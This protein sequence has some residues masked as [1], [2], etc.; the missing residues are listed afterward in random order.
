LAA[1]SPSA[2][3]S[4]CTSGSAARRDPWSPR[5]RQHGAARRQRRLHRH[6]AGKRAEVGGPR[7]AR[8]RLALTVAVATWRAV[9]S[10]P[11]AGSPAS[12]RTMWTRWS[13]SMPR[14]LARP[15][16]RTKTDLF[17]R[18]ALTLT[19]GYEWRG[20]YL[21]LQLGAG[22]DLGLVGVPGGQ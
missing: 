11:A 17:S 5:P 10:S 16:P 12:R 22:A 14:T 18:S 15:H 2:T 20:R 13:L 19:G 1:G 3:A 6:G 21:E 4:C 9:H 7:W 8:A